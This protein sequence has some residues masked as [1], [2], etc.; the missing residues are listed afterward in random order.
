MCPAVKAVKEIRDFFLR[1]SGPIVGH[2][3]GDLIA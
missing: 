3:A 1:N 2:L